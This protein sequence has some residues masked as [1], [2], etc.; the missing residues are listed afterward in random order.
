MAKKMYHREGDSKQRQSFYPCDTEPR[1]K[2]STTT[3][4]YYFTVLLQ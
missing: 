1:S 3:V 4:L 2:E